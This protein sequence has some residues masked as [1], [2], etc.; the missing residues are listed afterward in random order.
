[1][2]RGRGVLE[3]RLDTARGPA[4]PRDDELEPYNWRHRQDWNPSGMRR[5]VA[6]RLPPA[7]I[8]GLA[9]LQAQRIAAGAFHSDV[10]LANIV[11][12]LVAAAVKASA[13]SSTSRHKSP[14]RRR[15]HG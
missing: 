7:I 8:Q 14:A 1:M 3:P 6:M 5:M 15:R 13:P 10:S 9:W 11:S 12:E 4:R 2:K